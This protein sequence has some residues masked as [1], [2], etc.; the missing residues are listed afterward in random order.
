[1]RNII[2]KEIIQHPFD[3]IRFL[4]G[5]YCIWRLKEPIVTIFGGRG[6]EKEKEHYKGAYAC[7]G[8]LAQH[9]ISI[10]SGGGP[11]IMEAALCGAYEHNEKAL[12]IGVIG[13]DPN[14]IAECGQKAI[15]LSSFA[16]R[17]TLLISYAKGFVFFPGGLGTVDELFDVLNLIKTKKIPQC[18]LVLIG[19]EYW[20]L[21]V[22]WIE[23]AVQKKY[24]AQDYEHLF[25]VTDDIREAGKHIID[26]IKAHSAQ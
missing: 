14:F 26:G 10:L 20:Q 4:Y 17:K 21:I 24:I 9:N 2:L 22:E 3:Y 6:A 16:A 18:P 1:M 15:F 7:A 12:G 13:I 25:L 11:G 19:K 5:I 8:L 23:M